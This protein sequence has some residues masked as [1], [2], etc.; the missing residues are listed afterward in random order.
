MPKPPALPD[1]KNASPVSTVAS[2]RRCGDSYFV[3]N[4]KGQ[5][6]AFWEF[7]LRFKTDSSAD[8]PEKGKPAL[9]D[10]TAGIEGIFTTI[11]AL[12]AFADVLRR[13]TA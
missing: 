3:T 6:L 12:Q 4:G 10:F 8:G 11:D 7:N 2:I 5:T 1:L 9:F 13:A